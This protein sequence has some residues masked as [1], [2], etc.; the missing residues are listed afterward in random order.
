MCAKKR[1][2][3]SKDYLRYLKDELSKQERFELENDLQADPFEMEAMEGLES[4]SAEKAEED[5]LSLH[6]SLNKRL[7]RKRR[8][9]WYSI[10]AT[11]ASI[12]L[13][14]TIFL[15]IYELNPDGAGSEPLTEDTFRKLDSDEKPSEAQP[16]TQQ[17]PEPEAK[18][19]MEPEAQAISDPEKPLV[20]EKT[21]GSEEPPAQAR[22][23]ARVEAQETE[24][25]TYHEAPA[26][27]TEE[28]EIEEQLVAQAQASEMMAE[29]EE[30]L[31]AEALPERT[32][33]SASKE[34]AA[35]VA[36]EADA[37]KAGA[38]AV[39]G[40]VAGDPLS[41]E[42]SGIVL[43]SEDM[44]PLPGAVIMIEELNSGTVADSEGR[45]IIPTKEKQ[46]KV[47][48]SFIGMETEEYIL[49]SEGDNELV[50]KPDVM[51]LD[52]IVVVT[53][54]S[55]K[56]SGLSLSSSSV[57]TTQEE[58]TPSYSAAEPPDGYNSFRDYLK[59]NMVFPEGY[60][61]GERE[62]VVLK[63][64]VNSNGSI[65]DISTLRSPGEGYA[66]EASRLLLEGPAWKP[67]RLNGDPMDEQVRIRIVFKK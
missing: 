44:E 59:K 27:V 61:P 55:G 54:A 47:V 10:A 13:V 63:F 8:R 4:I 66:R 37:A 40:A 31:A 17:L 41:G 5:I 21:I 25:V 20:E 2:R 46:A 34:M 42:I 26:S 22:S 24:E 18:A 51:M 29:D 67:A 16:E 6:A 65:S 38:G 56:V 19:A 45:F 36:Y 28:I 64:T 23:T 49:R 52:E 57:K 3:D 32:K 48:A 58:K 1:N 53:H 7:S 33:R 14:G 50:M 35:P 11:A 15:N 30:N 12:L 39:A 43:S 60:V 9:T 62:I